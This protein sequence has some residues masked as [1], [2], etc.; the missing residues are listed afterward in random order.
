M[1]YY[2]TVFPLISTPGAHL[3][4]VILGG[5]PFEFEYSSKIRKVP[6]GGRAL[7]R[8]VLSSKHVFQGGG[9]FSRGGGYLYNANYYDKGPWLNCA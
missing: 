7:I 8:G 1:K 9:G 5:A 6:G 3:K 2:H 4:I